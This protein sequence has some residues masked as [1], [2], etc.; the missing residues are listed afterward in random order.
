MD[1]AA[2]QQEVERRLSP[3]RF[4]HTLAVAKTACSLAERYGADETKTLVA[5]L[6]HDIAKEYP[7][8]RLLKESLD[9]GIVLS[10]IERREEALIHGPLGAA[11]AQRE[12]GV[13]D[14]DVL[15]AIRYHT[16]GR[17]GMSLLERIIFVADYI[18]PNRSFPGVD[19]VRA[20]AW[21]SLDEAAVLTLDQGLVYLLERGK[22]IHPDAIAAR[23]HLLMGL[24]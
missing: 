2:I 14:P 4:R 8:N 18:E 22:L 23:N 11:I 17:E 6:L 21:T 1:P 10:E 9:F 24:E 12:F 16:T 7:R 13:T 5:A 15:A 3:G 20:I 19:A